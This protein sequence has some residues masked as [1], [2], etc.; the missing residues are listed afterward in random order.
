MRFALFRNNAPP[1]RR[2][3]RTGYRYQM[4]EQAL[5]GVAR[6]ST[7]LP[8]RQYLRKSKSLSWRRRSAG[9]CELQ[10]MQMSE[11]FLPV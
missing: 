7:C 2:R 8:V 3:W 11:P 4:Q 1:N 6:N 10:S 9:A 5:R